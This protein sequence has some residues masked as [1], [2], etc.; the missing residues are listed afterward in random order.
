M[1]ADCSVCGT[2]QALSKKTPVAGMNETHP[3][4]P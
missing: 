1:D 2:E 3:R 4:E